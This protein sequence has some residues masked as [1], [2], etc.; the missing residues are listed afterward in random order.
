VNTS[1]SFHFLFS[2]ET[3]VA[4]A[5]SGEA[6]IQ[7]DALPIGTDGQPPL[8]IGAMNIDTLITPDSYF[9]GTDMKFSEILDYNLTLFIMF[10]LC[11]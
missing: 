7:Y 1:V 2:L 5:P 11:V 8:P 3:A 6:A 4:S 10:L 9:L